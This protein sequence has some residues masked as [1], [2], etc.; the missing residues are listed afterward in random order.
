VLVVPHR[1]AVL[2]AKL[3]TTADVFSGGRVIAGVGSGWMPEEFAALGTPPF[4]ERGAVTDEYLRAWQALWTQDHPAIDGRHVKFANVVFRPRPVSSPH[5]PIW[6]GG[7]SP[8]AVRRAVQ[9]GN[10]WYP[11]SNNVQIKSDT[12]ETLK[13][14][15]ERLHWAAEKAGRD[16]ASIDIG[17][18]WFKPPSWTP[19]VNQDNERQMF[20]GSADAMLQDAAAFRKVGVKHLVVYAQQPTIEQTLDVQQRFAEDVVGKS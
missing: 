15:I 5:P 7:E 2:T 8:P 18:L 12:P 10:G 9:F 4:A 13:T 19:I 3:L 17:Y 16:P 11:A 6:V 1:P 20:S 14:G